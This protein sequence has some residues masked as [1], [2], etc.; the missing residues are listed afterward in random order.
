MAILPR[1]GSRFNPQPQLFRQPHTGKPIYVGGRAVGHV[2][3]GGD[4]QLCVRRARW[5]AMTA[6]VEWMPEYEQ[7]R[8]SVYRNG[9]LEHRAWFSSQIAA[10]AYAAAVRT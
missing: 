8:V 7:Y 9:V 10:D 2:T 1:T 6:V 3:G 4:R 5:C